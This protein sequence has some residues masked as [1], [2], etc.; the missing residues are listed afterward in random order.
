[1]AHT[2]RGSSFIGGARTLPHGCRVLSQGG[3][4]LQSQ[5][6]A[7]RGKKPA[8][9]ECEKVDPQ[10]G[11]NIIM[12]NVVVFCMFKAILEMAGYPNYPGWPRNEAEANAEIFA[13]PLGVLEVWS[14]GV[15]WPRCNV[16][17][18]RPWMGTA[19]IHSDKQH[20]LDSFGFMF[21]LF[22]GWI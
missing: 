20:G 12:S 10:Q 21:R 9:I 16:C 18:K 14:E 3:Q 7:Q 11:N 2:R 5:T 6:L 19:H 4:S 1:V 8:D 22:F 15:M 17:P 13:D